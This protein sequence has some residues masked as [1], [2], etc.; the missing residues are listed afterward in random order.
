MSMKRILSIFALAVPTWIGCGSGVDSPPVTTATPVEQGEAP[1]PAPAA[2]A[3]GPGGRACTDANGGRRLEV[4]AGGSATSGTG[5]TVR[6][7]STSHDLYDDGTTDLLL[8]LELLDADGQPISGWTPS[9]F[10][11]PA[12]VRFGE[13]CVRLIDGTEARI[14]LEVAP[15]R[16][17][18]HDPLPPCRVSCCPPELAIPAPD[19]TIECCFCEGEGSRSPE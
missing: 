18:V 14:V 9:A 5:L 3:P 10:S 17:A 7:K 6:F 1:P 15:A 11:K 19:G 2:E 4:P 13:H 8:D 16:S 12:W